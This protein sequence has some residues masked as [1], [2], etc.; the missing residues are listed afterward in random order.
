MSENEDEDEE[1]ERQEVFHAIEHP[2]Q[3]IEEIVKG[4][5][6]TGRAWWTP[7][8]TLTSVALTLSVVVALL[9]GL[10]FLAYYLA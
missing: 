9:I 1:A 3:H 7:F 5:D 8:V 2:L 6:R 4:E 10:A